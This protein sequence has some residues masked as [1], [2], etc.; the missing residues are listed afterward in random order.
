MTE[1]AKAI[2]SILPKLFLVANDLPER[3]RVAFLNYLFS[4]VVIYRQ[5]KVKSTPEVE[6]IVGPYTGTIIDELLN[7]EFSKTRVGE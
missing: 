6:S 7:T 5:F 1:S 2:I 4:S 3:S